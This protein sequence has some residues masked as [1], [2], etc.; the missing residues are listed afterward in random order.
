MIEVFGLSISLGVISSRWCNNVIKEVGK[1]MREFGYE[2][3]TT[4]GDNL[5]IES[6]SSIDV[7]E[8][9]FGYSF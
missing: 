8:E 5:I 6:E 7:F 3:Q 1:G 4:V 9:K 2:L